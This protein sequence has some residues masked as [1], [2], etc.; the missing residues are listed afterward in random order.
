MQQFVPDSL[1]GLK[2]PKKADIKEYS[3][4]KLLISDVDKTTEVN[5]IYITKKI[6]ERDSYSFYVPFM[7]K[8]TPEIFKQT[9]QK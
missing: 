2:L 4:I 7:Y 6:K 1:L 8:L 9:P 5:S 3:F